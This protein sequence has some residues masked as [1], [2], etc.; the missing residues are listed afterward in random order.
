[1][2]KSLEADGLRKSYADIDA[3]E[4]VSLTM[5]EGAFF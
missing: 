3:L 1:M 5:P 4:G 2:T